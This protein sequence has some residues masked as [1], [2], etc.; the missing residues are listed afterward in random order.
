MVKIHWI[1][2]NALQIVHTTIMYLHIKST[3]FKSTKYNI[4]IHQPIQQF[5]PYLVAASSI[6]KQQTQSIYTIYPSTTTTSA[7]H[8]QQQQKL[9]ANTQSTPTTKRI[10]S[11]TLNHIIQSKVCIQS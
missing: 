7:A 2:N 1:N 8:H 9:H 11:I 3:S 6:T 5:I 4:F 10:S